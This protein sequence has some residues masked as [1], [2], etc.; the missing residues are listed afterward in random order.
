MENVSSGSCTKPA[1]YFGYSCLVYHVVKV[2]INP[3]WLLSRSSSTS[4][5]ESTT[6]NFNIVDG[7]ELFGSAAFGGKLIGS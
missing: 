4:H 1:I 7:F 3:C 2:S 5:T 6:M